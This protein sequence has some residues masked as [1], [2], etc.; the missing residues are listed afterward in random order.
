MFNE[1]DPNSRTD[2]QWLI[3]WA[4]G[5]SSAQNCADGAA[6][7]RLTFRITAASGGNSALQAGFTQGSPIRGFQQEELSLAS[8]AGS[9]YL[10][11]RTM[12]QAGTWGSIELLAGPLTNTGLSFAYRDT[13]NA[14]TATLANIATVSVTIRSRSLDVAQTASGITNIKDSLI[15]RVGL[16]NNKRF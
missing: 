1:N 8:S 3:G 6:G 11:R 9:Y 4:S 16:R 14:T 5:A 13:L 7:T 2:D 12:N 10:G 15:T